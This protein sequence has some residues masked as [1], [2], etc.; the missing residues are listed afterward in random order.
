MLKADVL[1][2]WLSWEGN[3][4]KLS[5]CP[6][7]LSFLSTSPEWVA[8]LSSPLGSYSGDRGESLIDAL[9]NLND[10]LARRAPF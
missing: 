8:T 5:Y 10:E 7:G 6:K 9:N 1:A 3:Y 2:K 4:V